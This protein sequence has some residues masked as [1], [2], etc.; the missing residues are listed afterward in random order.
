[1]LTKQVINQQMLFQLQFQ[2]S[3]ELGSHLSFSWDNGS[4]GRLT[5]HISIGSKQDDSSEML[6]QMLD[7]LL[8]GF[9]EHYGANLYC[10]FTKVELKQTVPKLIELLLLPLFTE[11]LSMSSMTKAQWNILEKEPFQS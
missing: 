8:K 4:I 10:K 1:M 11:G 3:G 2:T 6:G 5:V 9:L 7:F